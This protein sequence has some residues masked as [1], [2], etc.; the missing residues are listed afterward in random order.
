MC[1]IF[2]KIH[3]VQKNR[4]GEEV[5][6]DT[7]VL[8]ETCQEMRKKNT[9]EPRSVPNPSFIGRWILGEPMARERERERE[10]NPQISKKLYKIIQKEVP[11]IQSKDVDFFF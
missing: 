4:S 8:S 6:E 2:I 9:I 3:A 5:T 7:R 10:I 1:T 11:V